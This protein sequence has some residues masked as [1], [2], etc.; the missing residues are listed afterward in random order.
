MIFTGPFQSGGRIPLPRLAASLGFFCW[1]NEQE[2][3]HIQPQKRDQSVTTSNVTPNDVTPNNEAGSTANSLSW[4]LQQQAEDRWLLLVKGVP[5]ISMQPPE[6]IA[7]LKR[8]QQ[9]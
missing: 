5:Q 2:I 3:W 8:Q 7:F 9:P 4:T 6:A 1:Q